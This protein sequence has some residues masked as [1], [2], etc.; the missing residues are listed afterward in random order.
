MCNLDETLLERPAL[1]YKWLNVARTYDTGLQQKSAGYV[2]R[3]FGAALGKVL[4]SL[5]QK[6][7]TFTA[8]FT[9]VPIVA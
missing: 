3:N 9:K 4:S 7:V 8:R 5:D 6:R 1:R 2:E